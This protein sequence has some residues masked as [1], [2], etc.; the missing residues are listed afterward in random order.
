MAEIDNLGS[1]I[2]PKDFHPKVQK[3]EK[4]LGQFRMLNTVKQM[5]RLIGF[6][7][8]LRNFCSY[9][10]TKTIA[11]QK[12]LRK[13]NIITLTAHQ[14]ESFNTLKAD[15]T[16]ATDITLRLAKRGLRYVILCDASF[17]GTGFVLLI[18]I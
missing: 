2:T 1:T 6:V 9:S 14:H 10:W 4:F 12:L 17:H 13:E 16:C 5:K 15:F 11:F 8:N 7:Q 3:T 18:E